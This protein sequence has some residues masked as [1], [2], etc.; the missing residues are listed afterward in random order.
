M[1]LSAWSSIGPDISCSTVENARDSVSDV[2]E[3]VNEVSESVSDVIELKGLQIII[4]ATIA[5]R[6]GDEMAI[7]VAVA[8]ELVTYLLASYCNVHYILNILYLVYT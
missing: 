6:L 7:E 2:I 8:S 5:S 3:S 4:G 1:C